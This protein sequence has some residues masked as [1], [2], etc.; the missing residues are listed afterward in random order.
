V[1]AA[2]ADLERALDALLE[3]ALAY[4]PA[5][6]T[7][8][9]SCASGRIEVRDRGPGIAADE[10]ELVFAR[11][12]RGRAGRYAARGD[13]SGLPI[14]RELAREW[15]GDVTLEDRAGGGT[16]AIIALEPDD[17]QERIEDHRF[18]RT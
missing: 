1:W 6:S 17:D 18:A 5:G 8:T 2:R 12:H 11:F 15:G 4:S 7:V 13:G 14:A 9:V 3:N 10:R 16:V